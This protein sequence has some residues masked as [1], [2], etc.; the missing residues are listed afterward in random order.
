MCTYAM[1][2]EEG[3]VTEQTTY[4]CTGGITVEGWPYPIN[5]WRTTG[6]GLETFRDGLCQLL[7]PLYHLHRPAAGG[8]DLRQIP[9]GLRLYRE[10]G[11][12]PARVRP[13]TLFHSVTDLINTPSDLAVESF[14]QNFS[15]TPLHM[16]TAAAAIANG[17]N[18]VTPHVMDRIVDQD[19][20]IV[21]T[22]DTSTRRQVISQETCDAIIDI[23]QQNAE[24]GSASGGYVAGYRVC[25]KTGHLGEG[26]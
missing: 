14:G 4:T 1:G 9:G 13:V 10:H 8:R 20:N 3:V 7:Q 22:A 24:S 15:I 26:G 25:G 2:L 17:G 16:I 5:C 23:L 12:R 6:H 11:H 18:L 19:G 21:E